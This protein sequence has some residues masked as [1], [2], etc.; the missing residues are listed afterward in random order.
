M[1]SPQVTPYTNPRQ[2]PKNVMA[3]LRVHARNS[4]VILP[5][6]EKAEKGE[7]LSGTHLWITH[8]ASQSP[9]AFDFMLSISEGYMGSYPAFIITTWPTQRLT[10]ENLHEPIDAL[11]RE[12]ARRVPLRRVYS[13][14]AP[15][16]ISVMFA[17]LWERHTLIKA[18]K[19]KPYYEAK[20]SFCTAQTLQLKL[21]NPDPDFIYKL[22]PAKV[23]DLA[24]VSSLC[25]EFAQGSD[26]FILE[27]DG[28][29]EEAEYLISNGLVWVCEITNTNT[30]E[31]DIPCIVAYTRNSKTVATITK[32]CTSTKWRGRKCAER[33]VA[34]VCRCFLSKA[35]S[36]ALYVAHDNG[37]ANKVYS[38][39]GF[40]GLEP[41][42][43]PVTGVDDWVEIGF[44]RNSVDL[45]HW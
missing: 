43:S 13:I 3:L 25:L 28:A 31:S 29:D 7:L 37:A 26:P 44:D 22:R 15:T 42:S 20:L 6:L 11:V 18:L 5:I 34:E 32:V 40:V 16:A 14:F 12:L 27:Q 36:V 41:G 1:S 24:G 38:N 35:D 19:S 23:D 33:L 30:G 39:V 10:R 8:K 21:F 45:G 4:N 2:I 17:E 9:N